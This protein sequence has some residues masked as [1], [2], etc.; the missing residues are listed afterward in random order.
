MAKRT[1]FEFIQAQSNDYSR[2]E[3]RFLGATGLSLTLLD[4]LNAVKASLSVETSVIISAYEGHR[5]L[6]L[7][8]Q[9]LGQQ[10]IKNFEVIIVDDGS[11]HTMFPVVEAAEPTFPVKYVREVVNEGRSFTRNTG[12]L[13]ADGTNLIFTDQDIIFDNE[14]VERLAL[15]QAH[16]SDSVFLGFKE[17]IELDDLQP[18]LTANYRSDWRNSIVAQSD[19]LMLGRPGSQALGPQD[20]TYRILDETDNLKTLGNGSVIGFWDLSATVISHGVSVGRDAA[21]MSGGF[22]EVGFDGWGAQDI[23]FGARLIGQGNFIIPSLD[24]AYFHIN[25]ERYSGSRKKEMEELIRNMASYRALLDSMEFRKKPA[26]R[27]P[28]KIKTI[29]SVEYYEV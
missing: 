9:R 17:D 27:S 2:E 25:H 15:K 11:P 5:T 19:F 18:G 4:D 3:N 10:S 6:P 12:M 20:R 26:K 13:M 29:G 1:L 8:L 24:T 16:T 23:A 28:K 7:M 21:V 22:P 14:F